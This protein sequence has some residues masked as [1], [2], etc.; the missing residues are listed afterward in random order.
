MHIKTPAAKA[1]GCQLADTEADHCR[2]NY[3][4]RLMNGKTFGS[5]LNSPQP[6]ED[7]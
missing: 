6:R 1:C 5:G 3:Q 4:P 7:T 2:V